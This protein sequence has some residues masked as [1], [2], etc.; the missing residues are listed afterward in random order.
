MM[1][2][3]FNTKRLY[4]EEGQVIRATTQPDGSVKFHDFSRM[5]GGTIKAP[6]PR[7]A[8]LTEDETPHAFMTRVMQCYDQGRFEGTWIFAE[9]MPRRDD[10]MPITSF[11]T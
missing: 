3:T 5:V 1:D 7:L 9:G 6:D 2:I 4:T 11:R 8:F 10:A